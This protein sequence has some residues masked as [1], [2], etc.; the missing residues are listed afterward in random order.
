MVSDKALKNSP[1]S[2]LRNAS[3]M[4]MITVASDE[5]A[6]GLVKAAAS[7]NTASAL[8][9]RVMRM[10]RTRCSTITMASSMISPT[11]A[12][13]P[14]RVMILNVMPSSLSVSTVASRTVGTAMSAMPVM[15]R[16]R[17]NTSRTS[18]AKATPMAMAS[19]TLQAAPLISSL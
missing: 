15:V 1:V 17:R 3:G 10:R 12:A 6:S 13:M 8:P 18:P 11:A 2:P 19:T 4:K 16:L 14:P 7:R 5:P 9:C